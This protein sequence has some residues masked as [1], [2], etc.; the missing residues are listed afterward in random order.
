MT[1][2][3]VRHARAVDRSI[4]L[5]D[6]RRP[7]T[8]EGRDRFA[9]VFRGL[10][11]LGARFDLLLHS[12]LLRA[13]ETA[14]MLAPCLRGDGETAVTPFLA[15]RPGASLLAEIAGARGRSVAVVGH[16]PWL[17]ELVSLLVTGAPDAADRFPLKKGGVVRLEG[18]PSPGCMSLVGAWG[19]SDLA[20]IAGRKR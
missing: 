3:V 2:W 6:A 20:A 7:L 1:L 4:S 11:G 16:E 5:R 14:E 10:R 13:I 18:E 9:E 17:S 19:P 8:Q 12:P 15:A